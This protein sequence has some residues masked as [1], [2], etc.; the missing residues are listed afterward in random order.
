[1]VELLHILLQK[2]KKKTKR[3]PPK[4]PKQ[5]QNSS[6]GN[7]LAV[8]CLWLASLEARKHTCATSVE[9]EMGAM[10]CFFL[11][12]APTLGAEHSLEREDSDLRFSQL[13][14]PIVET[15]HHDMRQ[16]QGGPQYSQ[17]CCS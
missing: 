2:K 7:R 15:P 3:N 10:S 16:E 9:L 6:F 11:N 1:M 12:D 5:Q 14:S 13:T 17:Q 8:I 4:K